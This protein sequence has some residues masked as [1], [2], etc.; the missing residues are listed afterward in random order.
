MEVHLLVTDSKDVAASEGL[1]EQLAGTLMTFIQCRVKE[2]RVNQATQML[3]RACEMLA[4]N[5]NR[6]SEEV[7]QDLMQN[8]RTYFPMV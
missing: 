3:V 2:E 7:M 4:E 1:S 8:P 6:S 5:E